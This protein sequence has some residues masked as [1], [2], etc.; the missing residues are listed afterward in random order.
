MKKMKIYTLSIHENIDEA[1]ISKWLAYVTPGQQ[2]RLNRF[3][4]REDFLRSLF[5][6]AMIRTVAGEIISVSPEKL[7]ISRPKGEKP[8]FPD[9][10]E[11]H[12]NIS[13]SGEWVI[14]A[15]GDT[16]VG[17]DIEEINNKAVS[18]SLIK[19]VLSEKEQEYMDQIADEQRNA[20][21]Y[22]FWTIKEAYVKCVGRGLRISLNKI[23]IDLGRKTIYLIDEKKEWDGQIYG[24]DFRVGYQMSVCTLKACAI[25]LSAFQIHPVGYYK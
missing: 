23:D 4:F 7:N 15:I 9:Y 24:I 12:F 10:P 22:R 1:I 11:L 16:Q 21:F 13:H 3:R 20:V 17:I 18:S 5:G 6:E 14:C 8:F 19:K 2:E 25:D